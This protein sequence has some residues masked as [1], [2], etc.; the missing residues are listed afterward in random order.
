MLHRIRRRAFAAGLLVLLLAPASS[1]AQSVAQNIGNDFRNVGKDVLGVWG[2]PRNAGT[3][4][5][6][7]LAATLGGAALLI[8]VDDDIDRWAVRQ[9]SSLLRPVRDGGAFDFAGKHVVPIAAGFYVLGLARNDASM[10]EAVL[11]CLTAWQANSIPRKYIV[12]KLIGRERPL[13][14]KDERGAQEA[15]DQHQW[16]VPNRGDWG[17]RSFPGGHVANAIA[18]ASF[19]QHRFDWGPAQWGLW[20]LA[21]GTG[22]GRILDRG[23]WTSDQIVGTVVGYAVGRAIAIRSRKRLDERNARDAMI[24]PQPAPLLRGADGVYFDAGMRGLT[25]GWRRNF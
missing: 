20:G 9:D 14:H 17:S 21:I 24:P 23:H 12:Y 4:E 3:S 25:L 22:V 13:D 1:A 15:K 19:W 18:C 8:P 11:G 10:R 5:W 2:S 16:Q 6:L 7:A